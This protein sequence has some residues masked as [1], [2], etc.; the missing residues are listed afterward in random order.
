V[1]LLSTDVAVFEATAR[2]R[3]MA[4]VGGGLDA[5]ALRALFA[6]L[7]SSSLP[8]YE[9]SRRA[10]R[11]ALLLPPGAAAPLA[12]AAAESGP[13]IRTAL[14]WVLP[15]ELQQ[16]AYG[17]RPPGALPVP[18]APPAALSPE[19]SF[20]DEEEGEEIEA[21]NWD[22]VL[23]L[24]EAREVAANAQL[25][26]SRE[27]KPIRVANLNELTDLAEERVCGLVLY[28]SWWR[29]FDDPEAIVA[30]V[31]AQ[32]AR[33]NLLYIKLDYNYLGA[34]AE[35][36]AALLDGLD[37][38]VKV[39][40]NGAQ[41]A[42]LTAA[43]LLALA[44]VAASLRA[45]ERVGVGVEGI[46][47]ADRRLLAAAVAAFAHGK[48]LPR[49]TAPEQLSIRPILEGRSG[50]NVL[51]VRSEAYRVVVVAKLD[52]LAVLQAEL[53]R[54]RQAIPP[55]WPSAGEM[56]LCTLN[57]RGVLLQRLLVDLDSPE[58]GAPS[59]RERLRACAAWEHGREGV[60]EP[61]VKLMLEGVDRLVDRVVE[62][63]RIAGEEPASGG[64]MDAETL[65]RLAG[66][67]VRWQ[68]DAEGEEFDPAEHL[69]RA[70]E[71]LDGH[72]SSRVVHGDL[73]AANLL[74]P[75]DRTPDLIDFALA[76][77]GHP[78]FDLVRISSAI[79]YE[80]IRLL[81]GEAQLRAL[82]TRLH[83]DGT[84]EAELKAEF[85]SLLCGIGAEVAL[86]ALVACRAAA[87]VA[88]A[89]NAEERRRQYLAMVYLVAAQS[90]TIDGFQE[91]V[92]RSALAA[93]G[94]TLAS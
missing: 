7:E 54:A 42:G 10:G 8:A 22:A 65:G 23:L 64:W 53:E 69:Q 76:G 86:H 37:D 51:A 74:M 75:D 60:P 11:I 93:V 38:E 20:A 83:L 4:L 66:L 48:H 25:L 47:A 63:N 5:A 13:E 90:L 62:L 39:R 72:G 21:E 49:F 50:A 34:A 26:A 40:V 9:V 79:A 17:A 94:P 18:L 77:S 57:G 41:G 70:K 31:A 24:G 45:A 28:G 78:C 32:I 6:E 35:P 81:E 61:R 73:H 27:M 19:E 43:D 46:D 68:V 91:G 88:I 52:R 84:G 14:V 80:F 30:F 87:L 92:V 58:E 89:G 16:S 2:S 85:P 82:F 67:E 33:S 71:I 12:A 29:Q 56:C 59:L 3:V 44:G 1:S 55:A 15:P 36:L